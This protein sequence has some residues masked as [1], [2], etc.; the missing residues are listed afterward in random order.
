MRSLPAAEAAVDRVEQTAA[1]D[2]AVTA[3]KKAV[4]AALPAPG[5]RDALHG[6]WL[7]HPLHPALVALP[8]GSWISATV[9]D[10]LPGSRRA[11]QT[12]VGLGIVT[13]VPTAAAGAADWS[14]LHPQ[15][16]R[17]GLVHALANAVTLGLQIASWRARRRGRHARGVALSLAAVSAGGLGA[18]LGRSPRVPAGGGGQPRRGRHRT[19]CRRTSP[20]SARWTTCPTAGRCGWC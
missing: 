18:Y 2:P 6:V 4:D 8:L 9:L 5:A 14:D 7:G 13:A 3:V 16:Q 10:L 19:S 15:Q 1:L 12:L 20:G 17:T 11:A